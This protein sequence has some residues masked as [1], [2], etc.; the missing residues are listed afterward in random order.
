MYLH[1]NNVSFGFSS[2][3]IRDNFVVFKENGID[4]FIFVS[5]QRLVAL[6]PKSNTT[7]F[8]TPP[9]PLQVTNL[10]ISQD[11]KFVALSSEVHQN[12]TV[13]VII[14][15]IA[16]LKRVSTLTHKENVAAI[17]F[18]SDSLH[19]IST[20]SSSIS[21][22]DWDKRK[23][24]STDLFQSACTR[25]SSP[26]DNVMSS[27]VVVCASGPRYCRLWTTFPQKLSELKI[28]S[29][30]QN[31]TNINFIDHAWL[32]NFD[33]NKAI[34]AILIG[35]LEDNSTHPLPHGVQIYSF[36]SGTTTAAR[37]RIELHQEIKL[38][39]QCYSII[40]LRMP[41]FAIS[42][43]DGTVQIY[44]NRT[45]AHE[46]LVYVKTKGNTE[47][48]EGIFHT[49]KQS[50]ASTD[51]LVADIANR[52][53]SKVS[54]DEKE[55]K[56]MILHHLTNDV[57]HMGGVC[58]MGTCVDRPL[59]VSCGL[60]DD[61]VSVWNYQLRHR[62]AKLECPESKPHSVAI[63]PS[64]YQMA[65][66][67]QDKLTMFHVLIDS[68][69]PYRS[70]QCHAPVHL[71][72]FNPRFLAAV[73]GNT[74]NLYE[75]YQKK[76]VMSFILVLSFT[77]HIGPLNSI[78]WT[79]DTLF[80][81]G[82]D[83]NLYG[84][85]LSSASRI[86]AM[87]VVRSFGSCVSIAFS[88][89]QRKYD[90]ACV[91]SDGSLHK[92]TWN[93][94]ISDACTIVTKQN[95]SHDSPTIVTFNMDQS[96]LLVGTRSGAIQCYKWHSSPDNFDFICTS[97]VLLHQI[98]TSDP[99]SKSSINRL[100]MTLNHLIWSAGE[101]DGS[102]FSCIVSP[103][104]SSLSTQSVI[105]GVDETILTTKEDYE[106]KLMLID[107]L[108]SNLEQ[109]KNDHEY[110]LHSNDNLWRSEVEDLS[111]RSEQ[112]LNAER[113]VPYTTTQ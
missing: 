36:Q 57:G 94:I 9:E 52:N 93:G 56:S 95:E 67:F 65:V 49:I 5:G 77:G 104:E 112:L 103:S 62:I 83:R 53:I 39:F 24:A 15:N 71:L 25:L 19:L 88:S 2:I 48:N 90:A 7:Q 99:I 58:D 84:W 74:I 69:K 50:S 91:T 66:G 75:V 20:T 101:I 16:S 73:V 109:L 96:A 31:E 12:K 111:C 107:T 80:S 85:N 14:Y 105:L 32:P 47:P 35:P 29:T 1:E 76:N 59:I 28:L 18:S 106:S 78:H 102:I 98:P 33:S 42:G 89:S 38:H 26:R 23:I 21:I 13:K 64:G 86:D 60:N 55:T 10:V 40:S 110:N 3:S 4:N 82:T 44:E 63:H 37:I 8:F 87:N 54:V 81:A 17:C 41:G 72:E 92:L 51:L 61:I 100:R 68:I 108:K 70:V 22:W 113:Y 79:D 11:E 46:R 6:E 30:E 97:Q 34:L 27:S 45:K 43:S